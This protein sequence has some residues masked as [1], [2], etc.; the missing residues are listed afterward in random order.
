[1]IAAAADKD[2]DALQVADEQMSAMVPFRGLRGSQML[3]NQ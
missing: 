1:L 3:A 2:P